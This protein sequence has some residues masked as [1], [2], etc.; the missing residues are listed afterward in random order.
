MTS[1][2]TH[3]ETTVPLPD[4]G[5]NVTEATVT[6]WLKQP[7]DDVAID[8]PILEVSTDKVD[9]EITSPAA[10]TLLRIIADED[11]VV[12][13]GG[14]LAVIGASHPTTPSPEPVPTPLP[15][16]PASSP[17]PAPA[18]TTGDEPAE[19][20]PVPV[21]A[22]PANAR[23]VSVS[24]T[25]APPTADQVTEK[26]P[27]IRQ[28]I[29]RRMM[30]SLQTSAQLTTVVEV[31]VTAIAALR[32]REKA[33]FHRRNGF[34]LSFL[35]YFVK[36]AVD[37]LADH[38]VINASLNADATEVTYYKACHLGI[39]VDSPKGLMVPVIRNAENQTVSALARSIANLAERVRANTIGADELS[40]GTFTITN[41]GSRGAL[42]DTPIINQPQSAILG[43]G[44]VVERVV[45]IRFDDTPHIGVRSVAYL[46]LSYDHRIIDGAD[47]ARYLGAVKT[48]LETGFTAADT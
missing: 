2:T 39:A 10:G 6:R 32:E 29:A 38:R 43:V 21:P 15:V 47:A 20:T 7:G 17:G 5:E 18:S 44:T 41:T 3:N 31:D 42:F 19:V 13:V 34:K 33:D 14:A 12:S 24:P 37:A 11:T 35:P 26:L 40:G 27:R 45:P 23:P 28:T 9:T 8:E 36:A 25:T 4:L 48:R 46:S 30:E 1:T 16:E 22:P